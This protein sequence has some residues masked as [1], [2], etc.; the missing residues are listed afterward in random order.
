MLAP[1]ALLAENLDYTDKDFDALRSRLFNLIS[2]VYPTWSDRNVANFGNMLIECFAFVGDVLGFYQDNQAAESRWSAARQR[3]N[4]IA[5]A[6][7]IGFTPE[8]AGERCVYEHRST[9]PKLC[10]IFDPLP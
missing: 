7:L 6:K 9:Q 3:K 8:G 4:L 5:L 10:A 1:M 2:S